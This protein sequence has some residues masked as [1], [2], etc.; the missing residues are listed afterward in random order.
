[1]KTTNTSPYLEEG[2]RHR[3]SDMHTRSGYPIWTLAAA[4]HARGES[5]EAIM[6]DYSLDRAEWE[7]AKEYYFAHQAVM[8]ARRILNE[9]EQIVLEPGTVTLDQ[10]LAKSPSG[11]PSDPSGE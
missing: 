10:F 8:D 7:A 11:S 4:W 6:A 5:D 2:P 3:P 9:E 1:M